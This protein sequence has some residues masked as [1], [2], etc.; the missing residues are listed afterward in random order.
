M[1]LKL[2]IFSIM[3][4]I[5]SS[6]QKV[7][8]ALDM[9]AKDSFYLVEVYTQEPTKESPRGQE[10]ISYKLFRSM[11]ALLDFVNTGME[12]AVKNEAESQKALSQAI[13]TKKRLTQIKALTDKKRP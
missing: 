3:L 2:I 5:I 9:V 7:E 4:P 12:E 1:K 10:L 13:E 6:A 8:Y 11:G